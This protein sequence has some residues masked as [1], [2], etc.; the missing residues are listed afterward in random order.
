MHPARVTLA[1]WSSRLLLSERV[2]QPALMFALLPPLALAPQP[3]GLC[4]SL[5]SGGLVPGL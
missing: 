1:G 2:R 3:R 4:C 5:L